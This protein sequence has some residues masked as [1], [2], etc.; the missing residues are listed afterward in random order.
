MTKTTGGEDT[1][2]NVGNAADK[3]KHGHRCY[4]MTMLLEWL[5]SKRRLPVVV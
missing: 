2:Q 4:A 1:K 3:K 5:L